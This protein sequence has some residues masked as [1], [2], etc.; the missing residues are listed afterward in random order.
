MTKLVEKWFKE[1][2]RAEG[3]RGKVQILFRGRRGD[4]LKITKELEVGN[5]RFKGNN[6]RRRKI[7]RRRKVDKNIVEDVCEGEICNSFMSSKE[8]MESIKEF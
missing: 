7:K 3:A 8:D 2:V 1:R 4:L 5:V 6:R